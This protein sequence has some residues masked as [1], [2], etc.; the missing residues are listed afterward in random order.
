MVDSLGRCI[1]ENR[2]QETND[3]EVLDDIF[4]P[5]IGDVS[6]EELDDVLAAPADE[7]RRHSLA[8]KRRRAE[9]R[10]EEKRLRDELGYFDLE[11]DD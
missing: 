10:L 9:K 3:T 11:L 8:E 7:A 6:D 4:E 2:S 1:V 5:I